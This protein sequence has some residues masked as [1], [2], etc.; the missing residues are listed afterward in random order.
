LKLGGLALRQFK[1]AAVISLRQARL[2]HAIEADAE[3]EGVIG[4]AGH[5]AES[6]EIA[7]L[8]FRPAPLAGKQVAERELDGT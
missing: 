7:L 2:V 5:G 8:C 4:V 3:V 1:R 6:A